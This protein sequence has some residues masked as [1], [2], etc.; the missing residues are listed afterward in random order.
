MPK[1]SGSGDVP[2]CLWKGVAKKLAS[3]LSQRPYRAECTRSRQIRKVKQR[4][5]SLEETGAV[6][7]QVE[8]VQPNWGV[9]LGG[10]RVSLT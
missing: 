8:T 6:V 2:A 5:V 4:R 10:I 1:A 3:R 7:R 9:W